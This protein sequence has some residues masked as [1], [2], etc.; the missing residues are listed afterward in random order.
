M[1]NLARTIP[2]PRGSWQKFGTPAINYPF[3]V[4][5]RKAM[6]HEQPIKATPDILQSNKCNTTQRGHVN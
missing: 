4:N 5:R 3:L 1:K 6:T 2:N